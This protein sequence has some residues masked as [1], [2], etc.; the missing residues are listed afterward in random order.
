LESKA[1]KIMNKPLVLTETENAMYKLTE[2]LDEKAGNLG[3]EAALADKYTHLI[4][5]TPYYEGFNDIV[6][7]MPNELRSTAVFWR[8][9]VKTDLQSSLASI[10]SFCAT[11]IHYFPDLI[12]EILLGAQSVAAKKDLMVQYLGEIFPQLKRSISNLRNTQAT[13]QAFL[14]QVENHRDKLESTV[15]PNIKNSII[16]K[17][18]EIA[19]NDDVLKA[20]RTKIN[21]LD[22]KRIAAIS[23]AVVTGSVGGAAI[24]VSATR[25][26]FKATERARGISQFVVKGAPNS[27]G[28]FAKAVTG[29]IAG[30]VSVALVLANIVGFITSSVLWGQYQKELAQLR[31]QESKLFQTSIDLDADAGYLNNMEKNFTELLTQGVDLVVAFQGLQKKWQDIDVEIDTVNSKLKNLGTRLVDKPEVDAVEQSLRELNSG[32]SR[33]ETKLKKY[34]LNFTLPEK[35]VSDVKNENYSGYGE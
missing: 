2:A 10:R 1:N 15:L 13:S 19:A 26:Y 9:T 27:Y 33:L 16:E 34:E 7:N 31:E 28:R 14:T 18:A 22:K 12:S 17:Q 21:Q 25:F 35:F 30:G 23:A 6:V 11:Y 5:E 8:N 3:I 32:F 20:C 29:K 24:A 4:F